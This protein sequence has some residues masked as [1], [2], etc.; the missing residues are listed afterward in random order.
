MF[1][2]HF[3]SGA[4]DVRLIEEMAKQKSQLEVVVAA[5]DRYVGDFIGFMEDEQILENTA[6]FIVPDHLLM[7]NA[8]F[9]NLPLLNSTK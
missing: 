7:D 5:V 9:L 4:F 3:P 6:I 2:R 8:F 1:A